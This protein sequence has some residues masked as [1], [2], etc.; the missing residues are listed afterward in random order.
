[1]VSPVT[2]A[3]WTYGRRLW[4]SLWA[5]VMLTFT[6]VLG[7]LFMAT[8]H[9]DD[10][11]PLLFFAFPIGMIAFHLRQLLDDSRSRLLPGGV[12]APLAAAAILVL[13]S[14]VVI[15]ISLSATDY[16]K[17][18]AAAIIFLCCAV[19]FHAAVYPALVASFVV[20]A[21]LPFTQFSNWLT[22]TPS[23]PWL[24]LAIGL[25]WFI[26]AFWQLSRIREA[27]PW[28]KDTFSQPY[29]SESALRSR[30]LAIWN[31]SGHAVRAAIAAQRRSGLIQR[32]RRWDL[33]FASSWQV[34]LLALLM[35]SGPLLMSKWVTGLS[36]MLFLFSLWFAMSFTAKSYHYTFWKF[37]AADM[38]KP[39]TREQFFLELGICFG[40]ALLRNVLIMIVVLAVTILLLQRPLRPSSDYAL[41]L[42]SV[43]LLAI[44]AFGSYVW[45][46]RHRGQLALMLPLAVWWLPAVLVCTGITGNHP[47]APLFSLPI[48][49]A[50]S[51]LFALAG[52]Y[53][54]R[55][56]YRRWLVADLG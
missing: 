14:L 15:S 48:G 30:W 12:R 39:V 55:D 54:A 3:L 4:G 56:A 31:T 28:V 52:V 5:V 8:H 44:F 47:L 38:L 46:F 34:P 41:A 24:L 10:L 53:L 37:R 19:A 45:S 2:A 7:P 20:W 22:H 36:P 16:P 29:P 42:A 51:V 25:A 32:S 43:L 9:P 40:I 11:F 6:G 23:A 18:P 26:V 21:L 33:G 27:T 13:V 1:M 49:F 50:V 17:L 35:S